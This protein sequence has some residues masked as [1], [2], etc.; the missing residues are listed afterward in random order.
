MKKLIGTSALLAYMMLL[1]FTA[2]A[3]SDSNHINNVRKAIGRKLIEV[4]SN[5]WADILPFYTDD[6]EYHDPIVTIKGI[7]KMAQFLG[8][9]F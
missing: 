4:Q 5:N 1:S 8:R 6:I 9:F 7:N 2:I 3:E